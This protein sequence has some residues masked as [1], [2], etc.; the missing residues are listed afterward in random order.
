MKITETRINGDF[1]SEDCTTLLKQADI[2]VTNPPFSL[3]REFIAWLMKN[4]KKFIILG[5]KNVVNYLTPYIKEEKLWIGQSIHSGE[6]YFHQPD[7]DCLSKGIG[8]RWFTNI[9]YPKRYEDIVLFMTYKGNEE[10]YPK[11][12]NYNAIEVSK[13]KEI[14]QDYDG[15]MGVPITFLDKYNPRQFDIINTAIAGY[16]DKDADYYKPV[17]GIKDGGAAY[18]KGKRMYARILIRRKAK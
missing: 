12:D 15:I 1:R 4:E 5:D 2:V 16:Y 8:V 7:S 18:L 6:R 9:D 17:D 11:Y 3:F 14:P 10:H 13:T